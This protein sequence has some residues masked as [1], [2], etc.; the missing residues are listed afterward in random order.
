MNDNGIRFRVLFT[1][2]A[3]KFSTFRKF[4]YLQDLLNEAE[5]TNNDVARVQ[6][7]IERSNSLGMGKLVEYVKKTGARHYL[8]D[9][10]IGNE[11]MNRVERLVA[12][13][14]ADPSPLQLTKDEEKKFNEIKNE[15]DN[16]KRAKDLYNFILENRAQFFEVATF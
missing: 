7:V 12:N 15:S 6:V 4:H 5:L 3:R 14:I 11:G 9:I 10:E 2:Y 8:S 13:T 1:L 16:I